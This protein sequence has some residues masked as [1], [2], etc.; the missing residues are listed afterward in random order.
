[1]T[2][3]LPLAAFLLGLTVTT[4]AP[5]TATAGD[6]SVE[7]LKRAQKLT[8]RVTEAAATIRLRASSLD[9]LARQT[10]A[11]RESHA[12]HLEEIRDVVNG[13]LRSALTEL[14]RMRPGLPAFKQEGITQMVTA[15]RKL[16]IET[17][18][19]LRVKLV[20]PRVTPALIDEYRQRVNRLLAN[21]DHL[22]RTSDTMADFSD[23]YLRAATLNIPGITG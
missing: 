23:A 3:T 12:A 14:D 21:A 10:S 19:A 8:A 5:R 20:D 1:M 13:Q 18:G 11:T 16:A 7:S 22:L 2:R 17:D 15:A 9:T 4:I 6:A